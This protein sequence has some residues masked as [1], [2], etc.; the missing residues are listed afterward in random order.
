MKVLIVISLVLC[1]GILANGR[2]ESQMDPD[3]DLVEILGDIDDNML[4]E[5]FMDD[6]SGG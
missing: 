3:A 4:F 1:C 5:D 6:S 2:A